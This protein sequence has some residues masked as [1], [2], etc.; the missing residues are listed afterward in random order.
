MPLEVESC[1]SWHGRREGLSQLFLS[2]V[3]TS[4]PWGSSS[5]SPHPRRA[6]GYGSLHEHPTP[7]LLPAP[8]PSPDPGPH[9]HL[10]P[11]LFPG[12][13]WGFALE[14]WPSPKYPRYPRGATE[15]RNSHP[16]LVWSFWTLPPSPPRSPLPSSLSSSFRGHS[17]KK[18]AR[19][20]EEDWRE[21]IKSEWKEGHSWLTQWRTIQEQPTPSEKQSPFTA[22]Q[23]RTPKDELQSS[24][25]LRKLKLP[26][27]DLDECCTKHF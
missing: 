18:R 16:A 17:G 6:V 26:S 23:V 27:E 22:N 9:H 2:P 21:K 20:L 7:A 10:H 12:C 8:K 5:R 13:C 14:H 11:R 4:Y 3:A 1:I 15:R 25:W 24:C 19:N